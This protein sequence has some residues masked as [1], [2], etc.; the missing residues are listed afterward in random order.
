MYLNQ[1]MP[2]LGYN[3]PDTNPVDGHF[4]AGQT[5]TP[6]ANRPGYV[7]N[8]NLTVQYMLPYQMVI[9][10]AY[11]GNHG[12][13]VWGFNEMDVSPAKNLAMGDTLIDNVSAHPQYTP[14]VGFPTNLSVAQA[15]LPYP[16]F[17]GVTNFYAYNTN[18]NYNSFQLTVTKHLS[19]GLGFIAAYTFSK[20]LG[21]QDSNGAT[22]YGVP[23]D[24]YNRRL[25][26]SLASFN[27]THNF[28]LTWTYDTPF[29]KG[30]KWDLKKWNF[31]LGGW[32]IAGLQNYASGLP[33]S[34][35]ST[36]LNTPTGFGNIRPD[37]VGSNLASGSFPSS[38]DYSNPTQFLN[39]SGFANVPTSPVNGVPLRVGTAPRNLG[40]TGYPTLSETMKMSKYFPFFGEKAK[41]RVGMTLSN[42]FKRKYAYLTDTGVGDSSFGQVLGGGGGRTMQLDA[43]VDF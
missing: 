7:Q 38:A 35:Y 13:R 3:L 18:S 30:R 21:Y 24:F 40:L 34:V 26:Y 11:V 10:G 25:E 37:V 29:G 33:I 36:G 41:A 28:K 19:T 43:R 1:P 9:E 2:S 22:G 23:Q 6:D 12:T 16:Q 20:T 8:W 14:Y 32:Q 15:M 31:I 27:Q 17:Y 5:V 39:A 4:N 42:P